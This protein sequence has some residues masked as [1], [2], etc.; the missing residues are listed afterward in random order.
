MVSWLL[1]V[2]LVAAPAPWS[3]EGGRIVT[4]GR[5]IAVRG[6]WWP[7]EARRDGV[8]VD[9]GAVVAQA[10]AG[11][12][13]TLALRVT[14]GPAVEDAEALLAAAA[15]AGVA[16]LIEPAADDQAGRARLVE[17]LGGQAAGW[18]ERRAANGFRILS[19][20]PAEVS[21]GPVLAAWPA[22]YQVGLSFGDWAR[23]M[24]ELARAGAAVLANVEV[25]PPAW[26]VE[27]RLLQAAAEHP[28]LYR[29]A[30]YRPGTVA[31][32]AGEYLLVPEPAQIR[33]A[34]YAAIGHGA[35]GVLF[36][37]AGHLTDGPDPDNGTD[38]AAMLAQLAE[39]LRWLEPF[40][41]EGELL[42][43]PALPDDVAGGLL[44]RGD[45]RLLLLWRNRRLD[46]R[47][48]TGSRT[49]A[50]AVDL[51]GEATAA[52]TVCELRRDGMVS[53]PA[54]L[55]QGGLRV[56]VDGLDLTRTYLISTR[57]RPDLARRI[58]TA[59]PAAASRALLLATRHYLKVDHTVRRLAELGRSAGGATW[60]IA[61]RD[62][63]YEA[64]QAVSYGYYR[65]GLELAEEAE[66]L[67]RD[68]QGLELE[69]ALAAGHPAVPTFAALP[70]L[71]QSP[72]A[73]DTSPLPLSPGRPVTVTFDELPVGTIPPR[74]TALRGLDQTVA[75]VRVGE[76]TGGGRCL[77]WLPAGADA[78][79]LY[80]PFEPA[81][82]L[83]LTVQLRL[84]ATPAQDR[85]LL[86]APA[87]GRAPL[88]GVVLRP[89]GRVAGSDGPGEWPVTVGAWHALELKLAGGRLTARWDGR[90]LADTAVAEPAGALILAKRAGLDAALVEL[91][92]IRLASALGH[93][94]R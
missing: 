37:Q 33:L 9:A 46:T 7:V 72:P 38:R 1:A 18:L 45:E 74:W 27:Q 43:C 77:R 52:T 42:D 76:G 50:F 56:S 54:D 71:Y 16:V 85:L 82:E 6:L 51:T 20:P 23:P 28:D 26:L 53:R 75:T 17:R 5:P 49:P 67:T 55:R 93:D 88:G 12:L 78:G 91:D 63:A 31:R 61:A 10:V 69:T 15:K 44:R 25:A 86:L 48:V 36:D 57:P 60:L 21:N 22:L 87:A 13:N 14:E 32:L 40:L 62:R 11:G 81:R 4:G 30:R 92:E 34:T 59:I 41:A 70:A 29:D 73:V 8:A 68:A 58:A 24:A 89:D 66:R 35:R 65:S 84:S 47:T 94:P 2:A 83:T 79:A 90:L 64:A 80:L 19:A 39:E 3:V